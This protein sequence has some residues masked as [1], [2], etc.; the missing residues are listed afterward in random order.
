M[1]ATYTVSL[2]LPYHRTTTATEHETSTSASYEQS[3]ENIPAP[4]TPGQV[5]CRYAISG[6]AAETATETV[7]AK[8]FVIRLTKN[9]VK[10]PLVPGSVSFT[11]SGHRYVDRLGS[12]MRDPDPVTGIGPICG[13]IDYLSAEATLDV[14]D[15]GDNTLVVHSLA[16]RLGSQYITEITFRAPGAPLRPG[17]MTIEGVTMHGER[18]S[19]IAGLDGM[20][21]APLIKG[22]V[23]HEHGLATIGFGRLV[24]DSAALAGEPWYNPDLVKNGKVWQP[25]PVY[26]DSL[27]YACVIYSYIPLPAKII[28]VNPVRLPSDGRVAIVKPGDLAVVHNTQTE[29]IAGTPAGGQIITLPRAA[30][31]VEIYDSS[32]I[33]LRVPSSMYEHAKGSDKI[34]IDAVNNDFSSFTAPLVVMHKIEDMR[35]VAETQINGQISFSIGASKPFPQEG[36]FVSTALLFGNLQAR[37]LGLFD[38]KVWQGK[39]SSELSGDPAT[40]TY[41]D[42][43]YPIKVTN[44][45]AVKE[46]WAFVFDSADHFKLIGEQR[47]VIAEGYITQDFAPLNPASGKP[48]LF[49]DYRGWGMGWAAGNALRLDTDGA[50]PDFWVVRTTLQGPDEEPYDHFTLQPRGDAR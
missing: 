31:S 29:P 9:A 4:T 18:I 26:A 36:T 2:S 32:E 43:D 44:S 28:G 25:E 23:D 7:A 27:K 21:D 11:W 39:F 22:G 14:Y 38:Q 45:G 8:P 46:R 33:P 10:L 34:T 6:A 48:Y 1:A 47:G 5:L 35:L 13:T 40:G 42:I 16:G 37:V 12:L 19:A 41:N 20:F 24:D 30:D 3:I 50:A 49:V 17:S 15:G